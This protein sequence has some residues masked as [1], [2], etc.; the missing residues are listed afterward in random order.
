MDDLGLPI[1]IIFRF[2]NFVPNLSVFDFDAYPP[3]Q[4]RSGCIRNEGVKRCLV[5]QVFGSDRISLGAQSHISSIL[6]IPPEMISL[7]KSFALSRFN[8]IPSEQKYSMGYAHFEA[9]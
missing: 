5:M 8:S 1:C 4:T 6:A 2:S 3:S 9:D 7:N